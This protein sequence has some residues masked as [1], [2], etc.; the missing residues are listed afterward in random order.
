M[1]MSFFPQFFFEMPKFKEIPREE[2]Y[3]NVGN[4]I[5][6]ICFMPIHHLKA[7]IQ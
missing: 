2:K 4:S 1:E 3:E 6:V 7:N 5:K